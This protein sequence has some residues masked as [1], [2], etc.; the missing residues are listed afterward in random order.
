[1]ILKVPR[2][3]FEG[4]EG[5][6]PSQFLILKAVLMVLKVRAMDL[7]L[8]PGDSEGFEGFE[9]MLSENEGRKGLRPP[10]AGAPGSL[11]AREETSEAPA[12][13]RAS[14]NFASLRRM[15]SAHAGGAVRIHSPSGSQR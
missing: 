13:R 4:R 3:G 14:G 6:G 2:D 12:T 10:R 1:M 5:L 7:P 9:G 11:A 8:R 15:L